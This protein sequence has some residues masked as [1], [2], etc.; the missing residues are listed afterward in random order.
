[1]SSRCKRGEIYRKG[2]TRRSSTGRQTRV[3]G[4]CI[5]AQSQSGLKR[6]D[7]DRKYLQARERIH[8]KI[9]AEHPI[10]CP[11]GQI[12]RSGFT[13]QPTR[14]KSHSRTTRSGRVIN[15]P[16]VNVKGSVVPPTCVPDVGNPGKGKQL[17]TL[18]RGV[19]GKYG[20][21]N[22]KNMLPKERRKAL[23][24]ALRDIDALPLFRRVG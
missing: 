8:Q 1:M 2:Y 17:F 10:W 5:R 3:S 16:A 6:S 14:R 24:R 21:S 23:K 12:A 7:L 22:V 20:Y 9:D 11:P 18:E 15:V 19:L 13:R 4:K